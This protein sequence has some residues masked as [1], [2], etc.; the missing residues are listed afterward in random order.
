[1]RKYIKKTN[2]GKTENTM[3]VAVDRVIKQNLSVR[4]VAKEMDISHQTLWRYVKKARRINAA[5]VPMETWRYGYANNSVF[6]EEE[7]KKL[8]N[9][10]KHAS[11]IYFGLTP[12]ELRKFA[13]QC[14]VSL[15]KNIPESW[16]L[17]KQAGPDWLSIFLNKHP[18][19]SI[20]IPEATSIG[21]AM[22][23]NRVR[24][25]AFFDLLDTVKEKFKFAA[26]DIWNVDETG[27]TTVQ[28]LCKVIAEKGTKQV[29][30]LTSAERGQL[31]T[32]CVAV[33]ATGSFIPPQFIFPRKRYQHHFIRDAPSGSIGSGNKSGWMTTEEFFQFMKHFIHHV[34]PSLYRPVLLLLDNHESHLAI[35]TIKLAKDNGVVMLSFP[36]HCS[37]KMQPLDRSVYGPFKKYL[38]SAQDA[39]MR[40]NPGKSMTIYNIPPL[41]TEALPKALTPTNI[42][43]GFKVTGIEP[44]NREIF[45]D[46]EFLAS[47]VTDHPE[48][49]PNSSDSQSNVTINTFD[50]EI[51]LPL[52]MIHPATVPIDNQNSPIIPLFSDFNEEQV[53]L[54]TVTVLALFS[55]Q[56]SCNNFFFFF[57]YSW[58]DSNLQ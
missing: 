37:H 39:W 18:D 7:G 42:M 23:F 27:V 25:D 8:V 21:R 48:P 57:S 1:M 51:V 11:K 56:H 2:R 41:V 6:N 45:S 4:S 38:S 49:R 58:T 5:E 19:L 53:C 43:N 40:N 55:K 32:V 28:K 17:N 35:N 14:A 47:T 22:G 33:N 26:S 13:Y 34:L 30:G 20:R 24:V 54:P 9:Y 3:K 15:N 52:L 29:G 12:I 10:I 44:M 36:P 46:Q 31:V 50:Q 16:L